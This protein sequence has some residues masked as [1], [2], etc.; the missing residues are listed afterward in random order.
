MC[1]SVVLVF[2]GLEDEQSMDMTKPVYIYVTPFFPSPQTWRGAHGYDFVKALMRL[3]KYDVKVF[4]P[5]NDGDYE[6][7]GVKVYGFPV[8]YLP[9]A[10]LPFLFT[11]WNQQSFLRKVCKIGIDVQQVE[12]CHGNTAYFSIFPL[13]MKKLNDRIHTL[14]HHHDLQSFGLNNGRLRH[15]WLHKVIN[16]LLLRRAF[17]QIDCH[18]F[19][20]EASR[21]SFLAVP[22]ASWSVYDEYKRQMRGLGWFRGTRIKKSVVLHN[23]VDVMQFNPNGRAPHQ[24]FVIGCIANFGKLKDHRS[25]LEAVNSLRDKLGDWRLRLIG[26]GPTLAW[27]KHYVAQNR[28]QD[29]VSFETEVDHTKLPDFYRSLDLFVLPSYFEGFGCVFTEAWAC[30]TPFITCEGQGMDDMILP[31]ERKY[32]L[33]KPMNPKDL[34]DKILN[35]YKTRPKQNMAGPVEIDG[36]VMRFIEMVNRDKDVL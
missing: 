32:W 19:I 1:Q 14:L 22:D 10:V 29:H 12:V 24:S 21:K 27:C 28:L 5:G 7:Q 8:K 15:V 36:L 3:E 13:A 11:R 34:A 23:G 4:V 35:F 25:L 6:Y 18:V 33:C 20:S 9:S 17:K 2:S 30:G 16:F 26:S 31:E